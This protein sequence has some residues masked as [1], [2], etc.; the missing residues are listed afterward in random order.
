MGAWDTEDPAKPRAGRQVL[1][2]WVRGNA[3]DTTID[4]PAEGLPLPDG[5]TLVA[6][7]PSAG[8]G[9]ILAA[10]DS[11]AG[12]E[13]EDD[14]L[15]EDEEDDNEAEDAEDEEDDLSDY[16]DEDDEDD[17]VD[18]ASEESFPASDPPAFTPLHI[19]S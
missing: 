9:A 16:E 1:D 14:D 2:S 7:L 8:T 10:D 13:D 6:F 5:E 15:D 17:E 12:D 11:F 18:E 19:G 4:H 3:M